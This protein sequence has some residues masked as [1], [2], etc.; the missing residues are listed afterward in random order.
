M[1]AMP[2]ADRRRHQRQPLAASV[3][4]FHA[5]SQREFPGRCVDMSEGGLC[6]YVPVAAPVQAGQP[7]RLKIG[8]VSRPEMAAFGGR[9]LDATIVHVDREAL[10]TMG[11]LSVGVK[12]ETA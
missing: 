6:M 4:F 9:S 1:Q 2:K 10:V 8:S 7:I 12:F 3:Q 5:P 11:Q